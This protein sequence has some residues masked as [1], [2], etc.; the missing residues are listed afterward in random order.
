MTPALALGL[1]CILFLWAIILGIMLAFARYG[2]EKN[3]PP[4][5]VWWHGGFAIVGFLILL[6]GSF[7]VGYPM[8]ANFGV[9]LIALAA[10]FGLWMY[11]NFHRKEV[12]IP[13]AIVWAH[14]AL[15]AVGFILIIM[16]M[17]NIADTAQV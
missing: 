10:I 17:L 12:L 13:I 11:F 2:K 8:L 16:A 14:G 3:P 1:A 7:F 6:Y 15:A 9:L 4:V 5:L